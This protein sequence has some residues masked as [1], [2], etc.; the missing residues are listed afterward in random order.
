MISAILSFLGGSAFR[1]IWGEVSAYFTRRQEHEQEYQMAELQSRLESERH[2]RDMARLRLQSELGIKEVQVA[3]DVAISKMEADAFVEAI[4]QAW[5]PTGIAWVDAWNASIRPAI[6]SVCGGLWASQVIN[7]G[8][9]LT[10]FDLNLIA[11]AL[12]FYFADRSLR[13]RGK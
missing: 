2:E 4:K 6:A 9:F 3:G 7:A 5:K 8:F 12:G 1:M 10:E 11:V 13:H